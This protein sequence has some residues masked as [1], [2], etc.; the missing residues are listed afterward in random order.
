[1]AIEQ[2]LP[3]EYVEKLA[4][5]PNVDE[6]HMLLAT[7]VLELR[8]LNLRLARAEAFGAGIASGKSAKWLALFAKSS[9]MGK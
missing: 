8:E 7:I 2:G 5:N 3:T 6:D 1:M 4:T 9:G